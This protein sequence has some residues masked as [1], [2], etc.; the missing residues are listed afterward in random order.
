VPR[1][2]TPPSPRAAGHA[3]DGTA[4]MTAS[5]AIRA[6]LTIPGQ[7]GKARAAREFIE[8]AL[9]ADHPCAFTAVLLASELVTN[10]M[11]YSNSR[12]P[13]GTI[14]ITVTGTPG[15]A[16]VEVRDAG[17]ASI[18]SPRLTD[19]LAE[20]GRGLQ[21]V[22]GLSARWGYHRDTR[23]LVTWFEVGASQAT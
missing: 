1:S 14:T 16:R 10:S 4:V 21:L 18:P 6:S 23:G 22:T 8:Q 11:L 20:Q 3:P 9:G 2:R 19:D 7:P 17:G 5:T 13:G 15:G 12:L